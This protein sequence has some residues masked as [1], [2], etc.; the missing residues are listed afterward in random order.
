MSKDWQF[1]RITDWRTYFDLSVKDISK[2]MNYCLLR[3]SIVFFKTIRLMLLSTLYMHAT[4]MCLE[5]YAFA[6]CMDKNIHN[7][8]EKSLGLKTSEAAC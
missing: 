5:M 8:I 6:D 2:S 1:N 3:A 4:G 7:F